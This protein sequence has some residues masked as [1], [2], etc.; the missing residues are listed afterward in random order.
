MRLGWQRHHSLRHMIRRNVAGG[1]AVR[2][3]Y[4]SKRRA[5]GLCKPHKRGWDQRW[6]AKEG[7]RLENA[8]REMRIVVLDEKA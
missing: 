1:M 7:Q 3:Q 5:C 8:E 6:T 4:K 2:K